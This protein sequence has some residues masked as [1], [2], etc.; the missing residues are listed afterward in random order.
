LILT[1]Y[2]DH[3]YSSFGIIAVNYKVFLPALYDLI[4]EIN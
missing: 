3:L 1:S 4:T 2:T